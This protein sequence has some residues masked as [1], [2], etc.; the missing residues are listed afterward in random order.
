MSMHQLNRQ[1]RRALHRKAQKKQ[2]ANQASAKAIAG[3][4][5]RQMSTQSRSQDQLEAEGLSKL[6]ACDP[7]SGFRNG[8]RAVAEMKEEWA[9]IPMPLDGLPLVIE[10]RY[11][12]ADKL[13]KI[14]RIKED[15]EENHDQDITIVNRFWSTKKGRDVV[16][17]ERDGRRDWATAGGVHS[18]NY[19]MHTL[20]A[21]D[22]WGIEQEGNAILTLGKMVR[23]RQFKQYMLTGSFLERSRRSGLIYL[24]RRLRPTVA[25][26]DRDEGSR[27]LAALCM[28]PIGYYEGSWAGAM[29]PT[30]DV[31]AHLSLMRGDEAMFWRRCNQHPPY[32]PEAGL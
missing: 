8:I 6:E 22:A 11:P 17:Y 19:V 31:I 4:S 15:D 30:D 27:I 9:G 25:I 13:S 5:L 14:G 21:S 23:H 10:P 16:I 26:R 1:Q 24:F 18:L 12:N 28:H 2:K 32:R 7:L 3:E 29:C 20:G